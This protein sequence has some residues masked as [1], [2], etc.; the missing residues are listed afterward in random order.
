MRKMRQVKGIIPVL[1]TP[2]TREGDIDTEGLKRLVEFLVNQNIGGLWVLGTGSEDMN[3]SFEK[4]IRVA[5]VVTET[6]RGRVPLIV[7]AGFFAMEYILS[8]IGE[9]SELEFEA[10]HVMPY[11]PLLSLDRIE[12]FYQHIADQCPK[13]LWVY[14]SANWS[15]PITPGFVAK[16]KDHPNI[17]GVKF[18]TRD[19]VDILKVAEMAEEGFQVI[20]A[21]VAQLYACL[22]M[23]S[24][25]HT[26]SLGSCLPE[27]LI[28]IYEL[29]MEGRHWEALR[30]QHRLNHFLEEMPKGAKKDNF[31]QA[32]EEKFILSLRGI[33]DGHTTSYYREVNKEEKVSI[34]DLLKKYEMFRF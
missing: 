21:V 13:P 20:T 7:G 24:Q 11:H 27:A 32:A 8:F 5:Q 3:L 2:L 28:T 26:S 12:W 22:C 9:T 34:T 16:I 18:S 15:R 29:F 33:C 14:T 25:A 31:L 6:N 23:G 4:R 30:A 10:Y 1:S 19:A 17:A